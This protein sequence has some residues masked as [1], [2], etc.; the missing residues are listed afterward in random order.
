MAL[1][2]PT[3]MVI[4]VLFL[5]GI[6]WTL[7]SASNSTDGSTRSLHTREYEVKRISQYL[8][9]VHNGTYSIDLRNNPKILPPY[10]QRSSILHYQRENVGDALVW[11]TL[12]LGKVK[13]GDKLVSDKKRSLE[14]WKAESPYLF[15]RLE[16]QLPRTWTD[17]ESF[18]RDMDENKIYVYKPSESA[19]GAGIRFERGSEVSQFIRGI[20]NHSGS[21]SGW[22]VQDFINPFLYDGRKTHLRA[23]TLLVIQPNGETE[24]F[25]FRTMKMIVAVEQFDEQRL[26]HEKDVANMVVTNLH[27]SREWFAKH[28]SK[29][30]KYDYSKYVIN[31]HDAFDASDS[32]VTFDHVYEGV[33]NIHANLYSIIGPLVRCHATVVSIYDLACFRIVAS[34]IAVDKEGN[35]YLLEANMAMAMRGIWSESE[36]RQFSDGTAALIKVP[37]TPFRVEK[38][39]LWD[40]IETIADI[41]N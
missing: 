25:Q 37:E 20:E 16:K 11:M 13:N 21:P 36:I 23:L 4:L 39:P 6:E 30:M 15:S 3:K 22:V 9:Y 38:S 40:K 10:S 34:D 31:A 32:G 1:P 27:Q 29:G 35:T 8:E 33:K 7:S 28:R 24:F 5:L 12:A 41:D 18:D 26:I 17:L 2:C 14:I 19:G